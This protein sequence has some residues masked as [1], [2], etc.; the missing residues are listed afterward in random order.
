VTLFSSLLASD[1]EEEIEI[2]NDIRTGIANLAAQDGETEL[3]NELNN[4]LLHD[5]ISVPANG[6]LL[7]CPAGRLTVDF[8]NG[9]VTHTEISGNLTDDVKKLGNLSGRADKLRSF[10]LGIDAPAKMRLDG[11]DWVLVDP[12]V[13]NVAAQRF[14]SVEIQLDMPAAMNLMASTRSQPFVTGNINVNLLRLGDLNGALDAYQAVPVYPRDLLEYMDQQTAQSYAQPIIP[15]DAPEDTTIIVVNTGENAID[16]RIRASEIS[17][18]NWYAIG[19]ESTGI[20][21]GD[22]VVFAVS[23]AH[24]FIRPE[25]QN[26][27]NDDEVSAH[28]EVHGE[29]R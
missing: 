6:D 26:R 11:G 15:N 24:H 5:Y 14:T 8:D 2:L 27:T 12:G 28:V 4:S 18:Q 13:Y 17:G 16:A 1:E 25:I 10:N 20:E 3:T 19:E 22:H 7:A 23:E 21:P 9:E 29:G